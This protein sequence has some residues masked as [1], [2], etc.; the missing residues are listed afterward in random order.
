MNVSSIRQSC[1]D[2]DASKKQHRQDKLTD[3]V[4]DHHQCMETSAI[5]SS[6]MEEKDT[7][8]AAASSISS[9]GSN[10]ADCNTTRKQSSSV[11]ELTARMV[12][13][14]VALVVEGCN[15]EGVE[16]MLT[17]VDDATIVA[18]RMVQCQALFRRMGKPTHVMIEYHYTNSEHIE[19]IR[20]HG[21]LTVEDR[22][23]KGIY[24]ERKALP[25][26]NGI[27]TG[28]NPF[29]FQSYGE[30]GL[31]VAV[32][33]GK[34]YRVRGQGN[35]AQPFQ[36]RPGM[37]TVV[38]NQHSDA[39]FH[40]EESVLQASAQVLPLAKFDPQL[41]DTPASAYYLL[42]LH[43][44][45]QHQILDVYFNGSV[46]TSVPRR[47]IDRGIT[48]IPRN[49]NYYESVASL[50]QSSNT[51][52]S[53][54]IQKKERSR[55]IRYRAQSGLGLTVP[56][57][58][59]VY[60][61]YGRSP[62]GIMTTSYFASDCAGSYPQ[63]I[64]SIMIT[65]AMQGGTQR[66]YHPHPGVPYSGT[67]RVAYLPCTKEAQDLLQR[68]KYAFQYGLTFEIS[69]NDK[70]V[71]SSI[72]HKTKRSMGGQQGWPDPDYFKR[73][74]NALDDLWVPLADDLTSRTITHP[75]DFLW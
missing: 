31:L 36:V 40:N 3:L 52:A 49:Q 75:D 41:L 12:Q 42:A 33:K 43:E 30:V 62:T 27:Y 46:K 57:Q 59:G 56:V 29:A 54:N 35:Y 13:E 73:C 26:G 68:L 48:T 22:I 72:P 4:P 9:A 8:V 58:P 15:L 63:G 37:D 71:W 39:P 23:A 51:A 24:M 67:S 21:L 28:N 17:K 61:A 6:K 14:L 38:G 64:G 60:G 65:Y 66:S 47:L 16:S 2:K 55:V 34:A 18:E 7:K 5:M 11:V 19:S 74:H 70:I 32:L 44:Q 50:V 1:N 25:F 53:N 20:S 45:I 69:G 10:S